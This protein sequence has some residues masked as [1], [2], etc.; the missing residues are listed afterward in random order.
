MN[1][2]PEHAAGRNESSGGREGLTAGISDMDIGAGV[3]LTIAED[4]VV[5]IAEC[6]EGNSF[7]NGC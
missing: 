5:D 3:A 6:C 1:L 2:A 4:T 7:D